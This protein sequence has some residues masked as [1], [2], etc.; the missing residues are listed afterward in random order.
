MAAL[1]SQ[2]LNPATGMVLV[3][4]DGRSYTLTRAAAA[5]LF[6][7]QVGTPAQRAAAAIAIVKAQ[8]VAALGPEQ[9]S[10][11]QIGFDIDGTVGARRITLGISPDAIPATPIFQP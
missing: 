5:A 1:R 6:Q 3:A 7:A 2:S 10:I 8:I 11:D 4:S 9:I